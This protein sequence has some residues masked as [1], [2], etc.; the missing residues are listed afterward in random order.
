MTEGD[1]SLEDQL[2]QGSLSARN[3]RVSLTRRALSNM[4][5]CVRDEKKPIPSLFSSFHAE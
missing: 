5:A 1:Q 4:E 2:L 3:V